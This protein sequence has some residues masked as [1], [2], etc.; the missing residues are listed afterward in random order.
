[1]LEGQTSLPQGIIFVPGPRNE[2]LGWRWAVTGFDNDTKTM[3]TARIDDIEPAVRDDRGLT[4]NYPGLVLSKELARTSR[5]K[6]Q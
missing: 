3:M 5:A 2:E 6:I 1:M 4:V